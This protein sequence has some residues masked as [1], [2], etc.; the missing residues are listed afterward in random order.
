MTHTEGPVQCSSITNCSE[1]GQ[2]SQVKGTFPIRL[3]PLQTPAPSSGVPQATH[4]WLNMWR[5]PLL[6]K[7]KN[8]LKELIEL[9]YTLYLWLQSYN[10][11]KDSNQEEK[12]HRARS[13]RIPN[14]K[15]PCLLPTIRMHRP[16]GRVL[17]SRESPLSFCVLSSISVSRVSLSRYD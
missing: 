4:N 1:S 14:T 12:S 6:L 10:N 11:K 16:P 15:F 3:P 13:R 5:F 8:S 2:T 17:L 7:F 9:K